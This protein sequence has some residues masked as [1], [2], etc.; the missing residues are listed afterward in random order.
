MKPQLKLKPGTPV[1]LLWVDSTSRYGWKY[2]RANMQWDPDPVIIP[3][4]G[5][6]VGVNKAALAVS[7]SFD[8]VDKSFLDPIDIPWGCIQKLAKL[9]R[10]R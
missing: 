3:T 6:V 8:P 4:I 1:K 7:H 2:P 5:F 10:G 9:R